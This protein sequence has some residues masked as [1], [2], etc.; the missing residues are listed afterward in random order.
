MFNVI[1]TPQFSRMVTVKVPK[2]DG[3]HEATFNGHFQVI[4]EDEYAAVTMGEVEKTKE[5]LRKCWIGADDLVGDDDTPMPWDTALRDRMLGRA[6]VR[7]AV[8][9]TYLDT[10]ATLRPGN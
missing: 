7:L 6:Y 3:Y 2:G 8:L 10:V 5:L 1:E 9:G 4:D